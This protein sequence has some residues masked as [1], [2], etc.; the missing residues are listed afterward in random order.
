MTK[1]RLIEE[2]EELE[3]ELSNTVNRISEICDE[4]K[5]THARNY[6][7]APMEIIIET[8]NW[9]S[10]DMTLPGWIKQ[11]REEL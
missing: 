10:H 9:M 8:G 4:L 1:Q 2:L 3:Q 7:I 5:D 11:L 6:L